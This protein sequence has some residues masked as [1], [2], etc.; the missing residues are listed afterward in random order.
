MDFTVLFTVCRHF[1]PVAAFASGIWF[2]SAAI[3]QDTFSANLPARDLDHNF[4]Q[5]LPRKRRDLTLRD[6][7]LLTLQ[8]NPEL[9]AF[10]KEM[11]ALEGATLQAGLLPNPELSLNVENIGNIQPLTGDINSQ[12]SVAQEVVQQITTIR[13]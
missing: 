1:V 5:T 9:A 12:K 11:R 8:R 2:I 4:R 6:A 13:I 7:A 3:A 10:A